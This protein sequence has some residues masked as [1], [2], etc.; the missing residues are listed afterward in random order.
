MAPGLQNIMKGA[1]IDKEL[2]A[3]DRKVKRILK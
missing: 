2:T 1:D 3:V